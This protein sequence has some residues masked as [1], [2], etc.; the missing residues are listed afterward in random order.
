MASPEPG[1]SQGK[2]TPNPPLTEGEEE[3]ITLYEVYQPPTKKMKGKKKRSPRGT[4]YPCLGG[5]LGMEIPNKK[6]SNAIS[7]TLSSGTSNPLSQMISTNS[8]GVL[9]VKPLPNPLPSRACIPTTVIHLRNEITTFLRQFRCPLAHQTMTGSITEE[10]LRYKVAVALYHVSQRRKNYARRGWETFLQT[11]PQVEF[12]DFRSQDIDLTLPLEMDILSRA[13]RSTEYDLP[14]C[15]KQVKT[16]GPWNFWAHG[17]PLITTTRHPTYL[18]KRD[19]VVALLKSSLPLMMEG[20]YRL[21]AKQHF[22]SIHALMEFTKKK[23]G[24]HRVEQYVHEQKFVLART[25]VTTLFRHFVLLRQK[26]AIV[27]WVAFYYWLHI[28]APVEALALHILFPERTPHPDPVVFPFLEKEPHPVFARYFENLDLGSPVDQFIDER[29]TEA[30]PSFRTLSEV[31]K[32]GFLA[33]H[34]GTLT[35]QLRNDYRRGTAQELERILYLME[36]E[37]VAS[38]LDCPLSDALAIYL[39]DYH[40]TYFYIE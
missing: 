24:S 21:P 15:T 6:V 3:P 34:A 23:L 14:I 12:H 17:F 13:Q 10:F 35:E 22:M 19:A 32:Q 2:E 16:E 36:R 25:K 4:I 26:E 5:Y 37:K 18:T 28:F 29:V 33:L 40:D 38:P 9:I 30:E 7:P 20:G 8:L 39:A 31:H 27:I 11:A 1:P